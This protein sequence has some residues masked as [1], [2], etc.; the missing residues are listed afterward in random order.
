[1]HSLIKFSSTSMGVH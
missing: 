1:M